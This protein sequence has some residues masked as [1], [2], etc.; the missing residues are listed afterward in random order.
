[1]ITDTALGD[2]VLVLDQDGR[3]LQT[4]GHAE[5]I[6]GRPGLEIVGLSEREL[7][8]DIQG[9][10]PSG[11]FQSGERVLSHGTG[12]PVVI[13]YSLIS[14]DVG[15]SPLRLAVLRDI[16]ARKSAERTHEARARVTELLAGADSVREVISSQRK[17]LAEAPG[18]G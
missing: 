15:P 18:R 14:V 3:V 6:F 1:M 10:L 4:N 5:A 9:P 13:E 7:F 11:A 2:A 17:K 16:T 8:G 12:Y